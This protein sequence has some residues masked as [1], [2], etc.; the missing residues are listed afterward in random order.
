MKMKM[1]LVSMLAVAVLA[2]CSDKNDERDKPI[3]SGS[4]DVAYISIKI[5]ARNSAARSSGENEGANES[6]L[7][8][9]YLIFFDDAGN[10]VGEPGA[11]A[12]FTKVEGSS[13]KPTAVKV[14]AAATK[15]LVIANPG[16]KLEGVIT[17]INATTTFGTVNLAIKGVDKGE[18]VDEVVPVERGFTMINSGDEEGKAAG[19]KI[20]DPLIGISDKIQKIT[21]DVS[22]EEAKKAAEKDDNR[23][24][25]RV[26]RLAS[27]VEFELKGD[28]NDDIKVEP[29]GATFAFGQWTLDAVNGTFFPF[30]EKNVAWSDSF[31]QRKLCQEFLYS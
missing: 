25:I 15:L 7:K 19:D 2:G 21:D 24:L 23:V 4:A 27:K 14:S 9:L 26:E 22:E 5:D 16:M 6:D 31:V 1:I 8:T 17:D 18:I 20:A 3:N 28:S 13:L 11:T 30:A 10:V 12:Y 29:S